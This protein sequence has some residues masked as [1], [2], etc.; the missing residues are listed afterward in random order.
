MVFS[1]A[2]RKRGLAPGCCVSGL[3]LA[4]DVGC[5]SPFPDSLSECGATCVSPRFASF[6]KS[7]V[8]PSSQTSDDLPD[9]VTNRPSHDQRRAGLAVRST[10]SFPI[11]STQRI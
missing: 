11:A 4:Q 9:S 7:P 10:G 2:V 8:Y 5:L 1:V 3:D 6:P